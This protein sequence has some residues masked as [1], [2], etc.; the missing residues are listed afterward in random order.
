VCVHACAYMCVC[1]CSYTRGSGSYS[2]TSLSC[3]S[4]TTLFGSCSHSASYCSHYKDVGLICT[5][6]S[7]FSCQP[8]PSMPVHVKWSNIRLELR[9]NRIEYNGYRLQLDK[10]RQTSI[11]HLVFIKTIRGKLDYS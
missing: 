6:S 9:L 2:I 3:S 5:N 11:L 7:K 1:V 8:W 4:S 10:K